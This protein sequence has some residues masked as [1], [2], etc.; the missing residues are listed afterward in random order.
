MKKI[1]FIIG[2][3]TLMLAGF[4][5]Q[6]SAGVNV[7]IGLFAPAPAYV[8]HEPVYERPAV[9]AEPVYYYGYYG[10]ERY[11]YAREYRYRDYDRWH[12]DRYWD[13]RYDRQRDRDDR[14]GRDYH[15]W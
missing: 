9:V 1:L 10:P 15:R 8:V 6:S 2:A 4:T 5:S 12:H 14:Y 3:V 13:H 11:H 7:H